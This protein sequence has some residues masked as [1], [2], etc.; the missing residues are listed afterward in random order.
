M[1]GLYPARLKIQIYGLRVQAF[2]CGPFATPPEDPPE[3]LPK[4]TEYHACHAFSDLR[5][6]DRG[7][8]VLVFCFKLRFRPLESIDRLAT[9]L[10]QL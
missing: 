8:L 5:Q 3:F 4:W 10:L 9:Q 6:G 1:P 7:R 2:L